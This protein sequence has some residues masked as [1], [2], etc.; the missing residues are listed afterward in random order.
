MLLDRTYTSQADV[1]PGLIT[2]RSGVQHPHYRL[3]PCTLQHRGCDLVILYVLPLT[4]SMIPVPGV[5]FL[6][7]RQSSSPS[8]D[9]VVLY[10]SRAVRSEVGP[11]NKSGREGMTRSWCHRC[12]VTHSHRLCS[13]LCLL[14]CVHLRPSGVQCTGPAAA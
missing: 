1:R 2:R 9:L 11:P 8:L 4:P 7:S 6:P 14:H 13:L 3:A 12:L 10:M 5:E